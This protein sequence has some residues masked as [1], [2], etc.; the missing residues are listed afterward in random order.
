MSTA[1]DIA[2]EVARETLAAVEGDGAR[3]ATIVVIAA[4][5]NAAVAIGTKMLVRD[6]GGTLGTLGGGALEAAAV[7]LA[8]AALDRAVVAETHR[9]A[10]DGEPARR[11]AEGAYDLLVETYA[12]PE[13]LLVV[14][15][16]HVGLS[17]ATIGEHLGFAVTVLDDRPEY[18][19]RERFPMAEQVICGDFVEELRRFAI[20]PATSVVVVTRG[21]K[22]D[23][24]SLREVVGRGAGYVGMIGSRRRVGAVLQH[25]AEDGLLAAELAA[26]AYADRHRHR[27]GDT[28]RDR[29]Q[30]S[31]PDHPGAAR[32]QRPVDG[33]APRASLARTPAAPGS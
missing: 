6:G 12:P 31:G 32:R 25:L 3:V 1:P 30:H 29:C 24:L 16:G 15:G 2:A 11:G 10:P 21:H 23:E 19:S 22:Q 28:G 33:R 14:G 13:A 18:A 20:T 7:R 9:L 17:L 5:G 4:P 8:L 27:R 26:G